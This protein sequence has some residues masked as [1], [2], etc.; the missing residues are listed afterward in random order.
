MKIIFSFKL[1]EPC[2]APALFLRDHKVLWQ[3]AVCKILLAGGRRTVRLINPYR[4]QAKKQSKTF[5]SEACLA[6]LKE[7]TR[8]Y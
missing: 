7:E 3:S 6:V 2:L 8:H 1:E 5:T 4:N